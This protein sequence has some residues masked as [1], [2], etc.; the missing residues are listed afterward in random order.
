MIDSSVKFESVLG[1]TLLQ[2]RSTKKVERFATLV[3]MYRPTKD[4]RGFPLGTCSTQDPRLVWG[5]FFLNPKSLNLP[6]SNGF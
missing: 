5:F 1:V 2:Q 6:R 4:V 3:A